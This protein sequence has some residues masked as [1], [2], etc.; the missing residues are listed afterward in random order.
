METKKIKIGTVRSGLT[1]FDHLNS[2][3]IKDKSRTLYTMEVRV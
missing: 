3:P 1:T 2:N